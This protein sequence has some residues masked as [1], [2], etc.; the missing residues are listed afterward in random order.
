MKTHIVST[1]D[2]FSDLFAADGAMPSAVIPHLEK[3]RGTAAGWPVMSSSSTTPKLYTSLFSLRWDV[4]KYSGSRYPRVPAGW[5][6]MWVFSSSA[7]TFVSP[8]SEIFASRSADS[9]IF[10]VFTSLWISGGW[11]ALCRCI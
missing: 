7:N 5:V 1:S 3:R 10:V 9:K 4:L 6:V 11:Q 2:E 8:K